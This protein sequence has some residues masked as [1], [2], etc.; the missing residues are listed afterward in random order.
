MSQQLLTEGNLL[1]EKGH[2][3]Q[4][5]YAT[6]PVRIYN[7][8]AIKAAPYKIKEWDY[9]YI[10]NSDYGIALTI[11]DNSYM[12]LIS[13]SFLDF[14]TKTYKTTS[15]MKAFTFGK[16]GMPASPLQGDIVCTGKDYTFKF[17][18]ESDSS[19]RLQCSMQKFWDDKDFE[20]DIK[21]SHYPKDSMTIALPF[22]NAPKAFYYNVKINCMTADGF[23][24]VGNTD[25]IFDDNNSSLGTLDW[26]RGVWTYKNTWYWA[27][28]SAK[29]EKGIPFGFNLGYGFGDNS[30]ASEN[31]IFYDGVAHKTEHVIFK[32]PTSKY[33]HL[34]LKPWSIESSD[35]RINL[36]FTPILDRVDN[37]N[38]LVIASFQHQVFGCFNGT[39]V[40]DNGEIIQVNNKLGFAERVTNKW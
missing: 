36:T 26:G 14:R 40:K 11:A 38:A 18:H 17:I 20:C 21:L 8:S 12:S 16:L 15:K 28:L 35:D 4:A 34:Y 22:P 37:T 31:M 27:S 32:I 1:D 24:K 13:A 25:Y 33:E 10:G 23:A 19:R 30:K 6:K 7:R 39:L 5:G 3:I 2:L 29:D 9:Y